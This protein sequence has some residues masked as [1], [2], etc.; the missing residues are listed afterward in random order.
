[1]IRMSFMTPMPELGEG[2][3]RLERFW[4]RVAG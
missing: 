3:D 4:K 2:L 1:M